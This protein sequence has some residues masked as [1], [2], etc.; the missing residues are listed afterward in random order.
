M[1]DAKLP[2]YIDGK[3][4][5]EA[6]SKS[7]DIRYMEESDEI[8]SDKKETFKFSKSEEEEVNKRLK[9]LGYM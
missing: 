8:E 1:L 2:T 4:L 5:Q 7:L 6:F 9:E 3:V